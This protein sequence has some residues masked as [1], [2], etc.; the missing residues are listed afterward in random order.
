MT[1]YAMIKGPDGQEKKVQLEWCEDCGQCLKPK[2]M[3][4]ARCLHGPVVSSRTDRAA[5][6]ITSV[7]AV[8]VLLGWLMYFAGLAG[9]NLG[10]VTMSKLDDFRKESRKEGAAVGNTAAAMT[11]YAGEKKKKKEDEKKTQIAETE[12]VD[13]AAIA[14]KKAEDEKQYEEN[15]KKAKG[16]SAIEI[17]MGG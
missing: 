9:G 8:M 13:A 12:K 3:D 1:I 2:G 11:A 5:A 4:C 17:A 10:G 6:V 14:K 15:K 16:K 7:L